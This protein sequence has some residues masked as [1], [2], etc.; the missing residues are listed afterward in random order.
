M[1]AFL[2]VLAVLFCDG[3][4]RTLSRRQLTEG[5]ICSGSS[6]DIF[7][8]TP[9]KLFKPT[10]VG[11]RFRKLSPTGTVGRFHWLLSLPQVETP[12][13]VVLVSIVKI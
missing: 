13:F 9:S 2:C 10:Y 4:F 6:F 12:E 1:A 8:T 11:E 5:T 7:D 3:V